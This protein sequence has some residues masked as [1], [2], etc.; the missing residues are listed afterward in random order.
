LRRLDGVRIVVT[1][2]AQQAEELAAPLRELGAEVILLPVIGIAPPADPEALRR[3]AQSANDYDWVIFT[4]ANAISAFAAEL[5]FAPSESKARVATVG[6][7][8]REAAE[9]LG[10]RVSIT[11]EKYVAESLVE[12]FASEQLP[13]RRILIPCAAVTR[14]VVPSELRKRGAEVDSVV[15]YRNV[16]PESAA[17]RAREVF[18]APGP[19][20]VIFASSS[21]VDNLVKFVG[22]GALSSV[23]IASIGP[24]TSQTARALGLTVAAEARIQSIEGLVEA[25][26][27]FRS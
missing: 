20:W 27:S 12:A 25:V 22:A 23:K 3:A 24:I 16:I 15:A 26:A 17:E 21:A 10:F 14:D 8:T 18:A 5:P 4:S 1:R 2:A 7:A 19:D 6:A 11:P 13:G 9:Q